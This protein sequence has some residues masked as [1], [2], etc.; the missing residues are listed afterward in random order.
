MSLAL[1]ISGLVALVAGLGLQQGLAYHLAREPGRAGEGVGLSVLAGASV[2][3]LVTLLGGCLTYLL[4]QGEV[5]VAIIVG[6]LGTAPSL[7]SGN[8]IGVLQGVQHVRRFNAARLAAPAVAAI[9]FAA[10]ILIASP[11]PTA[12]VG[13]QLAAVLVA[14]VA[15]WLL[16]RPLGA[17]RTPTREWSLRLVRYGAIVNLGAAAYTANRQLSILVLAAVG[18]LKNVGEYS[19]AAGYGLP[20]M[21]VPTAMAL[22]ALPRV[23][24]ESDPVERGRLARRQ[25]LLAWLG[26]VPV[27]LAAVLLAPILVPLAFGQQFHE[28]VVTSQ[29]L[30]GALALLGVSHVLSEICRGLGR[31]SFPAFTEAIG[32]VLSLGLLLLVVPKY[33]APGAAAVVL[34]TYGLVCFILS[35]LVTSQVPPGR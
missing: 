16:I 22:L 3:G 29:I 17:L 23:A 13:T 9:F 14:A 19:V 1:T 31:P 6:L 26:T 24:G 11:T 32:L 28:S 34:G 27:A 33:G 18:T 7:V 20:I 2:G 30:C 12:A 10:W 4:A 15:V 8:L 25:V 35:R 21:I 5:R